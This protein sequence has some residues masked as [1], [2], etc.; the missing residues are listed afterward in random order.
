M[1]MT[2]EHCYALEKRAR[3]NDIVR[4]IK[5]LGSQRVQEWWRWWCRTSS[6]RGG[7]SLKEKG[8]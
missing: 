5:K 7:R 8:D 4:R 6:P 3:A 2:H 1:Q